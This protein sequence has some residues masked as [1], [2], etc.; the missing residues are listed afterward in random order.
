M[1]SPEAVTIESKQALYC[2]CVQVGGGLHMYRLLT[3]DF[4]EAW[5]IIS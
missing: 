2:G 5:D 3:V 4:L 1:E